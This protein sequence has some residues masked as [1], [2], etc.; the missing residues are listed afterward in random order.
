MKTL[1][2]KTLPNVREK[3][4]AQAAKLI[5][6]GKLVAFPTETVYGLGANVFDEHAIKEIFRVKGRPQ[7]NPLIVHLHSLTQLHRLVKSVPLK[8]WLLAEHFMPGPLT[9]LL[10]KSDLVSMTVTAGLSTVAIRMPSHNVARALLRK[11]SVPIVAPSANLS[12]RPSPTRAEHVA[13]DLDG[14]IAAILDG[15]ACDVG[16]ES[17]VIDIAKKTPVIL[18]PGAV[19]KEQLEAVLKTTVRVSRPQKV[20]PASPGMKYAHYAPKAEVISFEGEAANV[21]K[22]MTR[23]MRLRNVKHRVGVM[24]EHDWAKRFDAAV[25]F[26]LG[27]SPEEAAQRLFNGF[28]TLDKSGV[29]TILCQ[30]FEAKEIGRAYMNRLRTAA[31]R[32]IRV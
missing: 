10:N 1:H 23:M 32:R 29:E 26:S 18:R 2:L 9:I 5:R 21:V 6:A 31:T 28:R 24:A 8:F 22:A 14:S 7:D 16:V 30:G 13:E 25:F 17:T 19:T 15:G 4:I 20:R 3:N 27:R 12:G 11:A